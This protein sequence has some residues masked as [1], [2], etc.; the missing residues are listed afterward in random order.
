[1]KDQGIELVHVTKQYNDSFPEKTTALK[2]ITLSI[3]KGEYIGLLGTNGSGK[4]TIAKL[5]NGLLKPTEGKVYV[6]GM[7]T[8]KSKNLTKIRQLVGIV[9]Q[10]PD[11]Q[12]ITPV[13]EEEIA[14][15]LENLGLPLT[16]IKRR[17]EWALKAFGLEDKR[18]HA[19]HLLSG[20][21]K[22][23]VALASVL[24]MQPEYLV[25]DEPA[26][27]LDPL[28]RKELSK[29]LRIFNKQEGMTIILISHDPDD[30]IH[31]DRLIVIDRGA[32][33]MRGTPAEVFADAGLAALDLNIPPIYELM[34]LLRLNG[35]AVSENVQSISELVD[36]LCLKL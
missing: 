20:G 25:L 24:A 21:Q 29:Q 6:N 14:F 36:D 10:N 27:M 32:I 23:R 16:E 28:S 22:Q 18:H 9:F 26:S 33:Y 4:S 34:N 19:P 35:Y 30:F 11:N 5:L 17:T 3:S 12:L 8:A 31:A 1:M 2:D 13:I 15:G 7:D